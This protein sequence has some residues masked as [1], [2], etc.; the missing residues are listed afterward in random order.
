[1]HGG[2]DDGGSKDFRRRSENAGGCHS[3]FE[4]SICRSGAVV[5]A[6]VTCGQQL[7]LKLKKGDEE[8]MSSGQ[9]SKQGCATS[10]E[11]EYTVSVL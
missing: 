9:A 2:I 5:I 1:M 8:E 7:K 3:R 11:I 6:I 10:L 4:F